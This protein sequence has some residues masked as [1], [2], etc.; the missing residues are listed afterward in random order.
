[1]ARSPYGMPIKFTK[2][3]QFIAALEARK[4]WAEKLDAKALRE[5]KVAEKKALT[6]FRAACKKALTWDY[7]EAKDPSFAVERDWRKDIPTCPT[8]QAQRIDDILT[9]LQ[10]TRQ[11][12]FNVTADNEWRTAHWLL[13]HDENRVAEMC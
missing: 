3:E 13:T 6:E 11:E 4:P 12:T 2:R 5:H 7:E 9:V 1:M 10:Q 8:S